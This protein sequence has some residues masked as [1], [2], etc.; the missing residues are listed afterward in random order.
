MDVVLLETSRSDSGEGG[1]GGGTEGRE[2]G[3][4]FQMGMFIDPF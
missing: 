4:Q 2:R 3:A 1:V